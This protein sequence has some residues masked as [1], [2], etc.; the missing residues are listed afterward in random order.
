[1]TWILYL[2]QNDAQQTLL[3][4]VVIGEGS[5]LWGYVKSQEGVKQEWV[6]YMFRRNFKFPARLPALFAH[7]DGVI[8][9]LTSVLGES[10]E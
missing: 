9:G 8:V 4:S 1:M 2:V 5:L 3:V 10:H 7:R 6:L